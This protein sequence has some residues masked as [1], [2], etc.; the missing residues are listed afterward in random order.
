[1]WI[2]TLLVFGKLTLRAIIRSKVYLAHRDTVSSVG[3]V[4][5][6]HPYTSINYSVKCFRHALALDERRTRFRPNVWGEQ[7][8]DREQELDVD[9]PIDW[10]VN[11]SIPDGWEY[12]A[13]IR[14]Q[15][16]VKEVWFAGNFT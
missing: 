16:D 10:E 14:D 9:I 5:Q 3:I 1:M 7:T 12:K 15:A 4:P 6:T 8:V 2:S 13:P 11:R